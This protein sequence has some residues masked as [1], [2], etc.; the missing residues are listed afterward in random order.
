MMLKLTLR[1]L[2]AHKK[3][4]GLT[5]L[6]VIL[7]VAFV[8]GTM[9]FSATLDK[10]ITGVFAEMGKGTD[11]VVRAEE[12][13]A[14]DVG[15]TTSDRPLPDS[16]LKTVQ[17][18]D[19][20]DK[21]KGTVTG[22]AALIDKKGELAG[23]KPQTG[24]DWSSDPD[25]SQMRLTS[26]TGPTGPDEIA[27]DAGTAKD[28]GYKVGDRVEVALR[29]GSKAFTISGIFE[30]GTSKSS[31]SLTITAFDPATAQRVLTEEPDTFR[32]INV[33]AEDGVSQRELRDSVAEVLPQGF[34]AITGEQALEERTEA[35]KDILN[36]L[37][38]FLLAFAVIA[39]FVGA[40]IIFNTFSMLVAQRTREMA[41][42]RAVGAS[43]NQ[44]TGSLVGEG[45]GVGLFGSTAGLVLGV[46]LA[47]GL[48]GLFSA[49]GED[50]PAEE[51][52]LPA[53]AVLWSYAV[54]M[55][56]TVLACVLPA[57]RAAKIPPIAALRD[58]HAM[59]AA[60]LRRRLT[61][62]GVVTAVGAATL[63]AGLSASGSAALPMVGA[64]AGVVFLGVS[65]LSPILS[66]PITQVVSWPFVRLFGTVGRLS[67]E[68]AQRN[69]RRT[70]STAAALMVGLALIG[71]VSI[72]AQSLVASVDKQLNAGLT[73]DFRVTS[74]SDTSFS[75]EVAA[76]AAAVPGVTG[77]VPSSEA[78]FKLDGKVRTA[79]AGDPAKL[80]AL[81]KL[82]MR[83]GG[84]TLR[85]DEVLINQSTAKE[86]GWK[87]GSTIPGQYQDSSRTTFRVAGVYDDV[88]TVIATVPSIILSRESYAAHNPPSLIDQIDVTTQPGTSKAALENA[89][90]K[91]PELDVQDRQTM[92]DDYSADINT[93]V[94]LVLVLLVL[95]IIIAALGI[96]NTLALSVIERTREIGLLR[97]VG[98]QRRQLRRMIRY[99]AVVIST[100]G[101]V[102]GLSIGIIFGWA[103]QSA[104][105]SD[106]MEELSVPFDQLG[107]YLVGGALVG[108]I[109][110]IWPSRTASRMDIL[111]AVESQ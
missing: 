85:K 111:R 48:R 107:M 55:T 90:A 76:A 81:Y 14:A 88:K 62:G 87:V 17:G 24:T 20:V 103:I 68:N 39:I 94:L 12:A 33:H 16:L 101:A 19:G 80:A 69:P 97:A 77:A 57:R 45:V 54:G 71:T 53:S 5:T 51:L 49:L 79:T 89:L 102:L 61:I 52:T 93:L 10:S 30:F 15:D 34:E 72:L 9:V 98:M 104:L 7:G 84:T 31:A 65:M 41:L 96:V 78:R 37:S 64:G 38:T 21:A 100:Y 11:T 27:I 28:T 63:V 75:D 29:Q 36:I 67:R 82:R 56:V 86:H 91:W 25:F 22:F 1:G 50:L 46:L 26:G 44:V 92:K 105:S 110:A 6:A 13:F 74:S 83:E 66:R 40:F 73:A 18:V 3:R 4:F 99:E 58:D 109:A 23:T 95:S 43:R 60:S 106:G 70:H 8:S 108:V 35:V 47:L 32:Q 2:L 59:P 42:L